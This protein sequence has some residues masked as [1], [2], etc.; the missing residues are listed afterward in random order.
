MNGFINSSCAESNPVLTGRLTYRLVS[1]VVLTSVLLLIYLA[2][3]VLTLGQLHHQLRLWLFHGWS[4][5]MVQ[6]LNIRIERKGSLPESPFFM[7]TNHLSYTDVFVLGS[8]VQ[9]HFV[10]KQEVASWPVWGWLAR[11]VGTIYID[12][13]SKFALRDV[14]QELEACLDR[15]EGVIVFPEGT[16]TD[17]SEILPFSTSIF[18]VPGQHNLPVHYGYLSYETGATDPP[19]DTSVCWWGD[20]KFLP[21]LIDLLQLSQINCRIVMGDA[22]L[23]DTDRKSLARNIEN[24]IRE[25]HQAQTYTEAIV[26]E[27]A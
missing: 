18:Y 27:T 23:F 5:A 14:N 26:E 16:T 1:I 20:M 13:N 21:H 24:E 19:A 10:A 11:L 7:V 8:L 4:K 12:R 17:G 3:N 2:A 25:L 6:I 9:T 15:G 22:S